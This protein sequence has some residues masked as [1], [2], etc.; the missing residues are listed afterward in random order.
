[1]TT[2]IKTI[3]RIAYDAECASDN[4][5]GTGATTPFAELDE[6]QLTVNIE[7][8]Q[9]C[10]EN[11]D[12][13]VFGKVARSVADAIGWAT[14]PAPVADPEPALGADLGLDDAVVFVG[15]PFD[16]GEDEELTRPGKKKRK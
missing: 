11:G 1:M 2:D 13:S 8:A 6:H 9:R 4:A 12:A 16:T 5:H 10:L 14:V 15:E 3:A 7:R